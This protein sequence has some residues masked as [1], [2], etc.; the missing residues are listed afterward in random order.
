[1]ES[2]SR[3]DVHKF[4]GRKPHD[5][6]SGVIA[7]QSKVGQTILD[8]FVGSG[9]TACESLILRRRAVVSDLDPFSLFLTRM[10]C[11]A[12]VDM[13]ALGKGY[14]V[15]RGEARQGIMD[16]YG[17][18]DRCG[19]GGRLVS[20]WVIRSARILK[21]ICPD[22]L[23]WKKSRIRRT[24][25][26]EKNELEEIERRVGM[27]P[28]ID[29]WTASRFT[30]RGLIA[31]S[32]LLRAI[33]R[34][35][36]KTRDLLEYAFSA[37]LAKSSLLNTRKATGKGW[38]LDDPYDL[39]VPPSALEF[40]VWMGFENRYRSLVA[41]KSETNQLIGIHGEEPAALEIR[42]QEQS[43]V[44]LMNMGDESV[45]HVVTDPPYHERISYS[46]LHRINRAWL[47]FGM[48]LKDEIRIT[49]EGKRQGEYVE[50][51]HLAIGEMAR[52]LRK[53]GSLTVLIEAD[54]CGSRATKAILEASRR[55]ASLRRRSTERIPHPRMPCLLLQF[56][57]RG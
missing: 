17:L 36:G 5:L 10:L 27:E 25:K 48:D 1:M 57:K 55:V 49:A 30:P 3:Y 31:L 11:L 2:P 7:R 45:D 39:K 20:H 6:V 47:G 26:T 38:I 35:R 16:L 40:N 54:E 22:C 44:K 41:A 32:L 13:E 29:P 52:V 19:C 9:T 46:R 24:T 28:G 14:G 50:D 37:N 43:A 15:V 18:A 42:E 23:D 53:Q 4:I 8:P 34:Q 12:P 21:T 56:E 33:R 51:M